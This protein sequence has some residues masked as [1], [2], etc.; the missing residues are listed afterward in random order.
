MIL[1]SKVYDFYFKSCAKKLGRNLYEYYPSTLLKLRLFDFNKVKIESEEEL[2]EVFHLTE[3]ERKI[4]ES[5][6]EK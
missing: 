1:N 3:A 2:Y 6:Y 4:I 5:D